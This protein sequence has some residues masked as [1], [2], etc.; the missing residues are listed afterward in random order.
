MANPKLFISFLWRFLERCGTHGLTLVVSLILAR[1]LG[2]E[3]FGTLALVT[4][5]T[6]VLQTFVNSGLGLAL[7]QK[8]DADSCDFSSVFFF[9]IA[10]SICLYALLFLF[11]PLFANFYSKPELTKVVRLLGITVII[12]GVTNIQQAYVSRNLLFRL[13]FFVTL[14]AAILAAIVGI[15][16]ANCGFGIWALVAQQLT[17]CVGVSLGLFIT[18]KWRPT[19]EF[20]WPRLK[21]LISYGWKLLLSALVD[22]TYTQ[23]RALIIGRMY[24]S[25]DLAYYNRAYQIPT[26]ISGN[27]NEAIDSVAFPTMAQAQN[28][29]QRVRAM[30]RKALQLGICAVAPVMVWLSVVGVPFVRLVLSEEWLPCVPYLRIFCVTFMFLPVQSANLN[31]INALGRSDI[32]L[33]LEI[34]KK[35]VGLS[36]M[37]SSMWFGVMAMAY[38]MI[39]QSFLSQIIN[40]WPNRKLI[41]YSYIEQ[42]RDIFPYLALACVMGIAAYMPMF[43]KLDDWATILLQTLLAIAVYW[44]GLALLKLECYCYLREIIKALLKR[45]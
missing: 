18:L 10:F 37:L 27:I 36:L 25:A 19:R 35:I 40:S 9:N 21:A 32:F 31:T 12:Y 43:L 44:A 6:E 4:A 39:V 24:T 8:K 20:S 11:A 38:A 28:D 16:M 33:K 34:C 3:V 22:R 7:V 30:M 17:Q 1:L 45:N 2:P 23:M 42:L 15:W 13:F 29:R 41:E 26:L 14:A 5:V